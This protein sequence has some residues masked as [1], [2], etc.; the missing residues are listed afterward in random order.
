MLSHDEPVLRTVLPDLPEDLAELLTGELDPRR[1]SA[2][3]H[4]LARARGESDAAAEDGTGSADFGSA[5][6]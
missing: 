4:A 5:I 6:G 3:V 1:A 2:L